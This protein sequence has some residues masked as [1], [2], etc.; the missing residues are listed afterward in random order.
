MGNTQHRKR[1]ARLAP[2][3]HG[4]RVQEGRVG[5]SLLVVGKHQASI[6]VDALTNK[7]VKNQSSSKPSE[8]FIKRKGTVV[9]KQR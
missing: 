6:I 3:A 4:C 5:G 2:S 8:F 1:G 9:K 7:A